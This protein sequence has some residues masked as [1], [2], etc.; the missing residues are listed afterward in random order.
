MS[1]RFF[2]FLLAFIGL[3][4]SSEQ[5]IDNNLIFIKGGILLNVQDKQGNYYDNI[6]GYVLFQGNEILDIGTYNEDMPSPKN[7]RIIDATGKYVLPGL[8]DGFAVLNNQSFAN[9]FLAKGVTTIIGVDGGRRGWFYPNAKPSPD[10]YRLESVGDDAKSDSAQLIDLRNIHKEGFKIALLKYQLRPNQVALLQQEAKKLGMGTIGELG[11]TSYAEGV[12][13]GVD[14]FVHTTRYSLD[15]AP[16]PM[17]NA[18]AEYPFSNDLNSPKWKY[19]QYLFSMDIANQRLRSHAQTLASGRSFIMP[20][21]SLLYADLPDH[22]NPWKDPVA[23]I[24]NPADINNP[25]D[26]ITGNHLYTPEEQDNYTQM[27]LQELKI[28]NIYQRYGCKYLAGSATDVWGSMPGISLHTELELLHKIGLSN[29]DVLR[30]ATVNFSEAFGWKTGKLQKGFEADILILDKNPLEDLENLN[31]IAHLFNNGAEVD[32]EQL[33]EFNCD[34]SIPDGQIVFR[35]A[36]NPFDDS[37]TKQLVFEPQTITLKPE[38]SFLK[39]IEMEEL[40]YMSDGLRVKAFMAY[41]KG[42]E[43]LPSIIYNRGGN[44][45]FSKIY[46]YRVVDILARMA[47]WGYVAIGSQYR[48][49]DGGDGQEEFGGADVNDV[50]NLIPLLENLP[51]ANADKIGMLGKSR[52]GMMTYLSLMKTDKI[53]AAAVVG[54]LSDL[55]LMNDGRGGEMEHY[56]YSQLMPNYWENKD[57]L[58]KERSAITRID[59]ISKSC[60]ILLMHGTADWRVSPTETMNMAGAFQQAEIPYRL[61]MMEGADHGLTE[62]KDEANQIIKEWFDRFLIQNE[63]L[64]NLKQHGK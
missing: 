23:K 34:T 15:I 52:G 54:G 48:G 27:G 8:I 31:S 57:A 36:Y 47:S 56:V 64:P 2:F 12:E 19:Y 53:I 13:I 22:K 28:E 41:P 38:F 4:C 5:Q 61:V 59:E 32:L 40:F 45:E 55:Q 11:Y 17:R 3:S 25:V 46:P 1:I 39:T 37:A 33:M 14:A 10:F 20:T 16:E 62:Y 30:A 6:K 29:R 7:A 35:Q 21:L 24:L 51:Q 49:N 58:L 44:R 9:A 26:K 60:P 63:K 42:E 43:Q 50:L 18:V